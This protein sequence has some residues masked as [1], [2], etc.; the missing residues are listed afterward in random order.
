MFERSAIKTLNDRIKEP[1]RF[2]K[3]VMG[4]RQ[5]GKTTMVIQLLGELKMGS[6]FESAD[7][8]PASDSVWIEQIWNN[9]RLKMAQNNADEFLLVIDEIQKIDNWSEIIKRLWDEDTQK[10]RN[11][12]V[13]LLGSSR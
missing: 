10:G 13:I 1:R 2:I 8:I 12:K 6:L 7:A 4:P 3:V 5:V 9:A 11:L